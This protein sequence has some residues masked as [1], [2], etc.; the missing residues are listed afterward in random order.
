VNHP[1]L[2]KV[3]ADAWLATTG[4]SSYAGE[5]ALT[6]A[7][8]PDIA[9]RLERAL[10]VCAKCEMTD[11]LYSVGGDEYTHESVALHPYRPLVTP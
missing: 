1:L 11:R 7:I 6:A 5:D 4:Q 8:P 10:D 9:D 3:L 2:T